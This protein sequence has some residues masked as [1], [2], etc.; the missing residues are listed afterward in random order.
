MVD[1]DMTRA[2]LFLNPKIMPH[3]NSTH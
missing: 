2:Q 3:I 1:K